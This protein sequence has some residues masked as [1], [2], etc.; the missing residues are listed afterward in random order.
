MAD[1]WET[2]KGA[3]VTEA[4]PV[5]P[6]AGGDSAPWERFKGARVVDPPMS[7]AEHAAL[8]ANETEKQLEAQPR[9][10]VDAPDSGTFLG[11]VNRATRAATFG[12]SDPISALIIKHQVKDQIP[13]LTFSEALR[14]VR[15]GQAQDRSISAEIVGSLI[16]AA[17]AAK[18]V[19]AA[20]KAGMTQGAMRWAARN[21][22]ISRV[23]GAAA[24]GGAAGVVEEAVRTSVGETID[25]T[26]GMGFDPEEIV[27]AT[28]T[29]A[30]VGA[31]MTPVAD[32]ALTG[33]A[34]VYRYA[35]NAF[36][37]GEEQSRQAATRIIRAAA[38][39]GETYDG[40]VTRLRQDAQNFYNDRGYAP[41]LA[42]LMPPDKVRDVADVVRYYSGLSGQTA[43]LTGQQ[44]TR[45]LESFNSALSSDPIPDTALI[46]RLASKQFDDVMA[47]HGATPVAI[48]ADVVD[49]L[50]RNKGWLG[51]QAK[52]NPAA[53]AVAEVVEARDNIGKLYE[54]A[55]RLGQAE[56]AAGARLEVQ[57]IRRTIAEMI[58]KDAI[59]AGEASV[60]DILAQLDAGTDPAKADLRR[61][62]AHLQ[63]QTAETSARSA[64]RRTQVD[65]SNVRDT[66]RAMETVLRDYESRGL[67]VSLSDANALR[68]K[69]SG[70]AN[71][72]VA[73][74]I[75]RE[76][77]RA[78]NEAMKRVGVAEVPDYGQAIENFRLAMRRIEAHEAGVAGARGGQGDLSPANIEQ[79]VQAG[80]T[81]PGRRNVR[82]TDLA[83]T[84]QGAREGMRKELRRQ[85]EGTP[86]EG[87][88]AIDRVATSSRVRQGIAAA[89]PAAAN[90]LVQR[91][92]DASASIERLQAAAS[93]VSP[94]ALQ[95]EIGA[96]KDLLESGVIGRLGGAATAGRI[97]RQ[98]MRF[99]IPRGT[100]KKLVDMLNDPQQVDQALRYMQA[101]DIRL[102]PFFGAMA[103]SVGAMDA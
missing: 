22:R 4:P 31:V 92:R 27:N 52:Y 67:K 102:G 94:S 38:R 72:S 13:D 50:A 1:P 2:Y 43:R 78:V 6:P 8:V 10:T 7:D 56:T 32:Q 18:V 82:G 66:V 37:H 42:E 68:Q 53:R 96:A 30:L 73:D 51:Q 89:D 62:A 74:P 11:W 65:L 5:T 23:V 61:L 95:E 49:T 40:T 79:W 48:P 71:N 76:E 46:S 77:S 93:K 83:A 85:V 41:S 86:S 20:T 99:K 84:R 55:T 19:G 57:S 34:G 39:E 60:D 44:L 3:T 63:Q 28:L 25:A 75:L 101:R 14:A 26:A 35:K 64:Q 33:A 21:P 90:D 45:V 58:N 36:G 91:A 98:M 80:V 81:P 24:S 54:K 87:V 103:A 69:A 88:A 9:L 15:T 100:A 70:F 59:E 17:G 16:P 12:L 97:A 29:G 47:A